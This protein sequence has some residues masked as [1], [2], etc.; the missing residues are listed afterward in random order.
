MA[1]TR[2]WRMTPLDA[3]EIAHPAVQ[4]QTCKRR[5]EAH[6]G[7]IKNKL[8]IYILRKPC[9]AQVAGGC[10]HWISSLPC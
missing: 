2:A 8:V 3:Q 10:L 5:A 9:H 6:D 1:A 4:G 7:A